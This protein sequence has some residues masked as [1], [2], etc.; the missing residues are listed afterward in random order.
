VNLETLLENLARIHRQLRSDE[1]DSLVKTVKANNVVLPEV[2]GMFQGTLLTL[3]EIK[4]LMPLPAEET[5]P[6]RSLERVS[7]SQRGSDMADM[8]AAQ[9]RGEVTEDEVQAF[10]RAQQVAIDARRPDR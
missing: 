5:D 2:Y 7:L 8:L 9:A 4:L 6:F 3:D 1:L 10:F